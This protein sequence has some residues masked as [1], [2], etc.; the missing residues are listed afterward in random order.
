MTYPT[1][2]TTEFIRDLSEFRDKEFYTTWGRPVGL[3][4]GQAIDFDDNGVQWYVVRCPQCRAAYGARINANG[5]VGSAADF[6]ENCGEPVPH[7]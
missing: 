7:D 2:Q 5:C 6:C 3:A 4:T 1:V